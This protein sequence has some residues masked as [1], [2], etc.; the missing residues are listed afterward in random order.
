MKTWIEISFSGSAEALEG[1]ANRAFEVGATGVEEIEGGIRLF[2]PGSPS[3]GGIL[4]SLSDY[5]RSL[6]EMGFSISDPVPRQVPEEDWGLAW[7]A[8]FK[9]TRVGNRF[10]V[11]P[12][13]E[14]WTA[15]PDDLIIDISPKMAFGTGSHETTRLC[16]GMLE[17]LLRPGMT[18]LDVGTGS[19]ILAIA[20]LKLGAASAAGLDVEEESVENAAENAGLNGVSD[21]FEVRLGSLDNVRSMEISPDPSGCHCEPRSAGRSNLMAGGIVSVVPQS[22]TPSRRQSVDSESRTISALPKPVFD[23]IL[24]NIDRRTLVPMIPEFPRFAAPGAM[25]ILSGILI[26]E[27]GMVLDLIDKPPFR[28][29]EKQEMKE[30]AGFAA[31]IGEPSPADQPGDAS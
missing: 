27:Q 6:R 11:K 8:Y 17:R 15:A 30:W 12:P 13:W 22:G 14:N 28:L 7:K 3:P 23:L 26:E 31:V 1:A 19:G 16:M 10:V 4:E 25:L 29:I 21:R 2:F 20:A 5:A 24:A 18:V 9:P